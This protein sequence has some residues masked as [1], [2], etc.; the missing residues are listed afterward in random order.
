MKTIIHL[1]DLHFGRND[2]KVVKAIIKT[3]KQIKPDILIVSGDL[4][5]R[6]KE[7]EFIAAKE[8]LNC[9]KMKRIV[10]PGNHDIPLYNPIK[11]LLKPFDDYK[12]YISK[13]LEPFYYDKEVSI[14]G[15]NTARRTKVT[16]G[17]ISS[18]Q[19]GLIKKYFQNAGNAAR[20]VVAHHPFDLPDH[21][22]HRKMVIGAKKTIQQLVDAEVDLILGGHMHISHV[23]SVAD[24]Y[25]VDGKAALV[26]QAST[27]SKRSR[28]EKPTFNVI[29]IKPKK[30]SIARYICENGSFVKNLEEDFRLE[31][32]SWVK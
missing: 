21:F 31:E 2:E 3:V 13:N 27:V 23:R 16:R 12:K 29:K 20:I 26:V 19:A 24:R 30:I 4:T 25:K 22:G 14:I 8:F 7:K 5:Q 1:S 18:D 15:L 32:T 28:G 9:F 11:R 6:A 17:K 10:I